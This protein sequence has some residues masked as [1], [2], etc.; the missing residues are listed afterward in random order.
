MKKEHFYRKKAFLLW[1]WLIGGRASLFSAETVH[2]NAVFLFAFSG[3]GR[4]R[5]R[6]R[7]NRRDEY[8]RAAVAEADAADPADEIPGFNLADARRIYAR[9]EEGEGQVGRWVANSTCVI[10][11]FNSRKKLVLSSHI[12]KCDPSGQ[13]YIFETLLPITFFI[14][15]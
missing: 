10:N 13:I 15:S 4:C 6:P 2:G 12:S 8:V 1:G 5:D 3:A 9:R 14:L 7:R 11:E